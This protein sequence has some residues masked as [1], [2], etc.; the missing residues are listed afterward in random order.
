MKHNQ[1]LQRTREYL[2]G[3]N[4]AYVLQANFTGSIRLVSLNNLRIPSFPLLSFPSFLHL[5]AVTCAG[6][7][8]VSVLWLNVC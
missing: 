4:F 3:T 5:G 6:V 2:Y 8:V 1:Y 7:H